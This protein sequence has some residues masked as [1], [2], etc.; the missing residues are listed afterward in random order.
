M[1]IADTLSFRGRFKQYDADGKPYLYK[2]GDVVEY[3]SKKYIAVK[4]TSSV[5]PGSANS[6]STWQKFVAAAGGGFYIQDD[7][8]VGAIEGDRWFRPT[9]AVMFT[10]IKQETDFI[11]VEL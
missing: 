6:E 11:W 8:P 1:N 3:K 2:I 4:A 5:I 9:P 10:L 7:P